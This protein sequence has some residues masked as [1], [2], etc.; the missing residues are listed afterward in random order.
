MEKQNFKAIR[1][2]HNLLTLHLWNYFRVLGCRGM[3]RSPDRGREGL[4]GSFW[5]QSPLERWLKVLP[6]HMVQSWAVTPCNIMYSA[7]LFPIATA[8]DVPVTTATCVWPVY[9][10]TA[11][12]APW[13]SPGASWYT[14][15]LGSRDRKEETQKTRHKSPSIF[16]CWIQFWLWTFSEPTCF[17]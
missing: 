13:N 3:R 10:S 16:F 15:D 7:Q 9:C 6:Q 4:L 17:S 8:L 5:S 12:S 11:P 1:H 14:R 2:G